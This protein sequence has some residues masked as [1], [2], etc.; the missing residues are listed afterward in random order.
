MD[1]TTPTEPTGSGIPVPAEPTGSA[2]PPPV[3]PVPAVAPAPAPKKV[4][5]P[6]EKLAKRKAMFK[7]LGIVSAVSYVLLL[8]IVFAWALFLANKELSLFNYLPI[9]QAS[10]SGFFYGI[11]NVLLG[12]TVGITLLM[13]LYGLLRSLLT[14]KEE[15]DKKKKFSRMALWYGLGFLLAT[16][17]WLVG[18][19]FLGPRLVTEARFGSPIITTPEDTI[20]L[21]SPIT[22][23]FDASLIPIDT[24]TYSI[25]AYTWNFGDGST[26]NGQTVTHE[27]TQKAEGNGIYTVTLNVEYMD[28]KSGARFDYETS[29]EV[30]I[31]NE[32]TAASFVAKPDSGEVPLLVEFDA[33]SSFDPDGEIVAYEWDFDADGRFD[34]AEGE[35]VEYEFLQEGT[36]EITLRVTDNNGEFATVTETIEAGSVGGLRAIITPPLGDGEIYYIDEEYDF[37][38]ELS[39]YRD[40]KIVKYKWDLGDGTKLESRSVS[41]TYDT[42]GDYEVSLTVLDADG[43]S[44]EA[45]LEIQV[46]EEGTPPSAVIKT[47]PALAA[48]SVSGAVPLK[49]DFDGSSSTDPEDDIVD[50]EWDF[51]NDGEVD[52]TGNK[53]TY[54]Y[55]ETGSYEARLIV[56]DSAGNSD[57]TTVAVQVG[58]QGI[59]AILE[60]NSSNGEVPLT[61]AF[62][63]SAS[64]YKEGDIV[65]YEIDFG[66]GSDLYVGDATVTYKYNAVGTYTVTL[67]VIGDDG[68][69]A[70]DTMQVVVRPVSLTACFTVNESTGNAPLF[71][72]VDPSCS[73]GTIQ[74]Y[75]WNFGDGE[76]SFD[77]KPGTHTYDSAGTY[78]ITLEIT[79]DTGIVD[80]ITKTITVK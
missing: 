49:V 32:M 23:T 77:R 70:T 57:E 69:R 30:V 27:Y 79:E 28:L 17:L 5:T 14:K 13:A 29:T 44:D 47:T 39:Q 41:H 67:T 66:D 35:I 74:S 52:E 1:E 55:A 50:Y 6:E 76:I 54:T 16:V 40:Q 36:Y 20:G 24:G 75:E 26:G 42:A 78:T 37:D 22:I 51:D 34:D 3:A 21:T 68:E 19:W 31:E 53:V 73:Q 2:V 15:V 7:R 59:V 25:L 64:T 10:M 33:T 58:E 63:A 61:I 60:S 80:S 48:G 62:D 18:I 71:V 56:T 65:S 9:S 12:V 45:I 11:F 4:L 8:V 46:V 43:N 72:V 38:G